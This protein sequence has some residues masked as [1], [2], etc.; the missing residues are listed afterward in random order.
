MKKTFTKIIEGMA[1]AAAMIAMAIFF[2][3]LQ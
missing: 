1:F 2:S 3:F